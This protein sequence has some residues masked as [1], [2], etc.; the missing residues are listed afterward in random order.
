MAEE[1]SVDNKF[2][3]NRHRKKK[4]IANAKGFGRKGNY[5]HGTQLEQEE[6][7]YFINILEAAQQEFE[8]I[9]EKGII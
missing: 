3:R 2:K 8:S 4:F 7:N 9:D 5:G 6:W 1:A